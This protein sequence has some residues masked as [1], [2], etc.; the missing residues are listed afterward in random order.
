MRLRSALS[1]KMSSLLDSRKRRPRRCRKGLLVFT[2]DGPFFFGAVEEFESALVQTDTDPTAIVIKLLNVP[3]ID[4]TGLVALR[5]AA[6]ALEKRGIV[7]ALC[8]A[9]A[10]VALRLERAGIAGSAG[11]PSTATLSEALHAVTALLD[12]R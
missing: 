12:S 9:N 6:D 4:L 1:A 10:D 8:C 5:D 3:F 2:V 7:V 11:N